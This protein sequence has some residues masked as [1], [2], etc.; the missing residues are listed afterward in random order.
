[1]EEMLREDSIFKVRNT[2]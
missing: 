1:L 2:L